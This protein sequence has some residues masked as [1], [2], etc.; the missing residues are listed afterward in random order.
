MKVGRTTA[1]LLLVILVAAA[2]RLFQLGAWSLDGD[3]IYSWYDV[4]DVLA[5]RTWPQGAQV[6][7]GGYLLIAAFVATLGLD[8]FSVRLG[9]SL[10]GLAAVAVLGLLRRDVRG[11][12]E[13]LAT[14]ALAASSPWLVYHAQTARFYGPL[15]LCAS[16]ALLWSLPGRGRRPGLAAVSWLGGVVCHPSAALLAPGLLAPLVRDRR[17]RLRLLGLALA[18]AGLLAWLLRPDAP[19]EGAVTRALEGVDPGR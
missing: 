15:L 1:G 8:E 5:G 19:L 11:P 7:P 12:G 18:G 17:G 10:C 4:Q 16:L 9:P 3:E 14:A 6:A 2:L 13:R